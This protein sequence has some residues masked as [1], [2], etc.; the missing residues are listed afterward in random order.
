MAR[1][2]WYHAGVE[3]LDRI[4][5][6]AGSTEGV[7]VLVL[8][9]SRARGDARPGSDWDFGVVA[10]PGWDLLGFRAAAV[11]VL[12]TDDVDVVDLARAT[13]LLR[14]RAASEGRLLFERRP[15]RWFE[16]RYEAVNFW[17]E[18]Q[19]AIREGYRRVLQRLGP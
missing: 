19:G 3:V 17:C 10:T 11:E 4:A 7:E 18:N 12:G 2:C 15:H 9:G 5:A 16:F 8:I 1:A 6:V 14:Y 13:A